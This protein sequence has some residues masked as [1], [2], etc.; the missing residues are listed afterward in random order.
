M[1]RAITSEWGLVFVAGLLL[2]GLL[3]I[4][5]RSTPVVAQAQAGVTVFEGA[6]LIVGDGSAPIDN[7][8]FIVQGT[9]FTQVGR[10]GQVQVPAGARRV[11][12]R[13]KTVM[14]AIIATRNAAEFM[15]LTDAGT[16]VAGKSADF[17]VLD[18]NP[19]DDIKNNASNCRCLSTR[20]DCRPRRC[21]GAHDWQVRVRL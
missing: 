5:A 7:A 14:P 10:A 20:D 2:F 21:S 19:L 1:R 15:K 16:V 9:R 11:D 3:L 6:R 17:L 18:A 4:A 13:G 8:A 12:L